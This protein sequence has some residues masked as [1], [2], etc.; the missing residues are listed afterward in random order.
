[1]ERK[2]TARRVPAVPDASLPDDL[3]RL[4]HREMELLQLLAT[5]DTNR[6]IGEALCLSTK[7][8]EYHLRHIFD[9]LQ[10]RN[11]TQAVVR[12][13]RLGLVVRLARDSAGPGRKPLPNGH[14]A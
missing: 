8:V 11:R 12:A 2:R 10:V 4:T 3:E 6:C 9:K 5:G 13:E 7:T 1:M 14:A